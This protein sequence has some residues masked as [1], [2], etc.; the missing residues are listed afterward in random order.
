M[1]LA[2]SVPRCNPGDNECVARSITA[3]LQQHIAGVPEIGLGS[4]D[5]LHFTN[6]EV[7]TGGQGA[8]S[9]NLTMPTGMIKGWKDLQVKKVVYVN[10]TARFIVL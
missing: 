10:D 4:I 6:L 7:V 2:S 5:P 8:V 1:I 9:T 3:I